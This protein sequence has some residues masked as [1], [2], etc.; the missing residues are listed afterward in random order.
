MNVSVERVTGGF[1]PGE[2]SSSPTGFTL[3]TGGET[4]S[5]PATDAVGPLAAITLASAGGGSYFPAKA[6]GRINAAQWP[7]IDYLNNQLNRPPEGSVGL[8]PMTMPERNDLER[9]HN[10]R[11]MMATARAL[12]AM[13]DTAVLPTRSESTHTE[14]YRSPAG[15]P[16]QRTA[17]DYQL[18]VKGNMDEFRERFLQAGGNPALQE[19]VRR[20]VYRTD[21]GNDIV[22][23]LL[24]NFVLP[25]IR[26]AI[27]DREPA[28]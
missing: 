27:G 24:N 12:E 2:G 25:L 6:L 20:D 1:N 28:I 26:R 9:G 19:A 22:N 16:E 3:P 11:I 8:P 5:T 18:F 17:R 4:T 7:G 21:I 13:T 23:G 14:E 10:D 15:M